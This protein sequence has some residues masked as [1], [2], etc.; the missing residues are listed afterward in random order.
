MTG[1]TTRGRSSRPRERVAALGEPIVTVVAGPARTRWLAIDRE[2]IVIGRGLE[3]E[4]SIPDEGL[5][6]AHAKLLRIDPRV[7]NLIDLES[8]NGTFVNG[9]RIEAVVLRRGDQI[10]LGPDTVL[11][12]DH[13]PIAGEDATRARVDPQVRARIL[14][15]LTP[16]ELE[17]ATLVV[18]G[19]GNARVAKRLAISVRTV[20]SHLDR[21]YDK[22]DVS[23]RQ[24]LLRLFF[25][26][27][28]A[29]AST[30]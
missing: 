1:E 14:A 17:V 13:A 18:A 30:P 5:S 3:A 28:L 15:Q 11:H 12:F 24:A 8:K 29:C 27:D 6:R 9:Q 22:L 16:R 26:A 20:E 2:E 25:L 19:L 23:S 7:V 21:I 4:L 10:Q